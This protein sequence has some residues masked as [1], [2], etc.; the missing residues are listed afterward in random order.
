MGQEMTSLHDLKL[1]VDLA[2]YVLRQMSDM[3]MD[4]TDQITRC[5]TLR[6]ELNS[7]CPDNLTYDPRENNIVHEPV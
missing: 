4:C 6:R 3:G 7:R 1:Q 5:R 2:E